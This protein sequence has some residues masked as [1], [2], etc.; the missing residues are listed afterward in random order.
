MALYI[1]H[2][3]FHLARLLY[4]R[5]ETFGPYYVRSA[6]NT[7]LWMDSF[8]PMAQLPCVGLGPLHYRGFTIVLRHSTLRRNASQRVISPSQRPLLDNTNNTH[9]RQTS[10]PLAVFEPTIPAS[11][12]SQNYTLDRA[13]A[14]PDHEEIRHS[15]MK[16][17]IS[18]PTNQ[19]RNSV[20]WLRPAF[21]SFPTFCAR[22]YR[23][24]FTGQYSCPASSLY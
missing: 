9:N 4:V 2:S 3:I 17:Y 18:E 14:G 13:A 20:P 6:E 12:R 1:P 11:Q 10:T 15:E 21:H 22:T 24:W 19:F 16:G 23:S 7:P 8:S 5:P